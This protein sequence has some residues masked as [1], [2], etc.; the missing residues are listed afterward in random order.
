MMAKDPSLVLPEALPYVHLPG[1]HQEAWADAFCNVIR[2]A[3]AW[4]R[5]GATVETK[6]AMLPTFEDGYR[7]A[8][9]IDAMLKSHAAGGAWQSVEGTTKEYAL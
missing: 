3:Y 9:I 4:I 8:C 7:S 2:E 6:P 1:G 5:A